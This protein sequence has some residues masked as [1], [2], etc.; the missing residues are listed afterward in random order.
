M[1]CLKK[2]EMTCSGRAGEEKPA[3]T[4]YFYVRT[5]KPEVEN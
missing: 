5:T 1:D 3:Y 2:K 4:P